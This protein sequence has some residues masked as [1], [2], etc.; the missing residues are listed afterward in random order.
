MSNRVRLASSSI[1]RLKSDSIEAAQ[2]RFR[3]RQRGNF[4]Q[5]QARVDLAGKLSVVACD[6]QQLVGAAL[7]ALSPAALSDLVSHLRFSSTIRSPS[8]LK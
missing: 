1:E 4:L 8:T 5:L 7:G 3:N 6:L 2:R